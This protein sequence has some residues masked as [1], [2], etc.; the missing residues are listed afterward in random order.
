[1]QKRK[2]KS[3]RN[4][5]RSRRGSIRES[6]VLPSLLIVI[7][8]WAFLSPNMIIA[9]LKLLW[10]IWVH[11]NDY[12]R[13]KRA[14]LSSQFPILSVPLERESRVS[15]FSF[16]P[17]HCRIHLA[18]HSLRTR[19]SGLIGTRDRYGKPTPWTAATKDW[20]NPTFTSQWISK[21]E[22][23]WRIMNA[24]DEV[25]TTQ[26]EFTDANFRTVDSVL[27]QAIVMRI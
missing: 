8:W 26:W 2:Q 16:S 24:F 25:K 1:M 6:D 17:Q 15:S 12:S 4:E 22:M 20:S 14:T 5:I 19:S 3:K 21:G 27:H 7:I 13:T 11:Q 9:L 23:M 10:L 18:L